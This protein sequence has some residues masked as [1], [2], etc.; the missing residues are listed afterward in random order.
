MQLPPLIQDFVMHFGEMGSRWGINRTVG[1]IYALLYLKDEPLN[2]DEIVTTLGFA[3]SSVAAGLKE[4]LGMNL[5]ML[6]HLPDDRKDYYTTH[7]NLWD[8]IH[9]LIEARRKREIEPTLQ[10]LHTAVQQKPTSIEEQHAQKKMQEMYELMHMLTTWY[11]EM[12]QIET[13]RLIH[14][15]KMGAKVYNLYPFKQTRKTQETRE[16]GQAKEETPE[17]KDRTYPHIN[18]IEETS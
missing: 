6:R 13:E 4:L 16:K 17:E 11:Q 18:T 8:M 10:M 7:Q 2:A 5:V 9:S 12:Q 14:L 3:R 15:M 1:Q